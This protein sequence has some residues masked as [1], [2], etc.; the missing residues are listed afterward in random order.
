MFAFGGHAALLDAG[1]RN[2]PFVRG[3]DDLFQ[4]GIG[5]HTLGDIGAYASNGTALQLVF[6]AH[7]FNASAAVAIC[8]VK[9]CE[10]AVAAWARALAIAT[11]RVFPWVDNNGSGQT[12]Q[13]RTA[14]GVWIV[15][16]LDGPKDRS[17]VASPHIHHNAHG[18]LKVGERSGLVRPDL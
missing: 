7:E 2:D 3:F 9:F 17:V 15:T 1:A 10:T 6:F 13:G 16:L 11:T 12:E 4:I 8:W 18:L 5:K 14:T